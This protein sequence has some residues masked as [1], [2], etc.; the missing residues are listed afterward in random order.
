MIAAALIDSREPDWVKRLTFGDTPCSVVMLDYGDIHAVTDDGHLLVI[1]RKTPGD[2]LNSLRDERLMVQMQRMAEI[3]IDEQIAG[4][5]TTWPYL[6][7]TGEFRHTADGRVVIDDR[8]PTGW[9]WDAVQGALL[10]IQEMGVFTTFC[11]GDRDFGECVTRLANRKRDAEY[12][13]LPP[14]PAVMIGP[15]A[16][17]LAGLPGV[18]VERVTALMSWCANVPA[19]ALVGIT[20]LEIDAPLPLTVREKIRQLLGLKKHQ[21]LELWVND[22]Q[23]ETF[24]VMEKT[25]G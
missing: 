11:N 7:V 4:S 6:V 14:R 23:H 13:L 16:A 15:G 12:K 3:R 25:G 8:G 21:T 19:H 10:T 1:E 5:L 24:R 17:F 22:Q 9:N 20:D 2:F 18:G